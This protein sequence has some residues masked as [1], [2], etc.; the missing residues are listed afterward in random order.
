MRSGWPQ[1]G[2]DARHRLGEQDKTIEA[3][4]AVPVGCRAQSVRL[5]G[6]PGDMSSPVEAEFAKV[7]IIN[8]R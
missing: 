6:E 8:A 3:A 2:A 1:A 5:I 4:F 7:E